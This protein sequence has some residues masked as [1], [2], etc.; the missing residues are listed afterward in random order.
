MTNGKKK[1]LV[2]IVI[3]GI[4]T[5]F[6]SSVQ[7]VDTPELVV[8]SEVVLVTKS[9]LLLS[10]IRVIDGDT[11]EADIQLPLDIVVQKQSIRLAGYDAW[12]SSKRR[13]SVNVTD[14]EVIKGKEATEA[15]KALLASGS[16]SIK[17]LPGRSRDSYGRVLG[18]AFVYWADSAEPISVKEHMI[19]NGHSRD[20]GELNVRAT[21]DD[22]PGGP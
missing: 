7:L 10:D 11:V 6:F 1:G 3:I 13:R 9:E 5:A 2:M 17:M 16:V 8:S 15:L 4:V 12:E 19:K 20:T 21:A 18:E 22:Y 14:E